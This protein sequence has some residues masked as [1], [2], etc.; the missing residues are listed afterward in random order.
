MLRAYSR[1]VFRCPNP[2]P[3]CRRYMSKAQIDPSLR[4]FAAALREKQPTL[5]VP[6]NNIKILSQPTQFYA[7]LLVR[8]IHRLAHLLLDQ[9]TIQDMI[10]RA[11]RR[12]FISSLYIG[13]KESQFVRHHPLNSSQ[14]RLTAGAARNP[15]DR[16]TQKLKAQ[17]IP[18]P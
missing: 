14:I 3:A 8:T 5:T 15:Q 17:V 11:Q 13:S 12:I 9:N 2:S 7:L 1:R 18:T 16:L 4:E 10:Q 6:P